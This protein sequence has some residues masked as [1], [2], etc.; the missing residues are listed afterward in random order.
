MILLH[1]E[2]RSVSKF[3]KER[4]IY[5][6]LEKSTGSIKVSLS[7]RFALIRFIDF[8]IED[9]CLKLLIKFTI[10]NFFVEIS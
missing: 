7:I 6:I 3:K 5:F 2:K 9:R 8:E 1:D 10:F 4:G